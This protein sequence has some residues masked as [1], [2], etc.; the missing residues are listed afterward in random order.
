MRTKP[1]GHA[2]SAQLTLASKF[3]QSYAHL[4]RSYWPGLPSDRPYNI[5]LSHRHRF[6]WYRV[7]KVCTRSIFAAFDESEVTLDAD[8]PVKCYYA[9]RYFSEYFKFAFVRNPWDRL[10]SC[11]R[12]KVLER[13]Y[14]DLTP[15]ELH[16]LRD[17]GSFVDWVST[18]D[19]ETCDMHLRLQCRLI[20]L[21]HV[22][23]VGRFE[24]FE[25]DFRAVAD[26]IRLPLSEVPHENASAPSPS[27]VEVY[28]DQTKKR[29]AEIYKKD[30]AIFGFD[31]R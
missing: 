25:N 1:S 20:D 11:W 24:S 15:D 17:F 4:M 10:A 19:V 27:F 5:S 14:F 30:I 8:H 18:Q 21:D 3:Y 16:L 9:P 29:V 26:H 7:A 2:R 6:L 13:N 28:D 23:F 31:F 22:D 12:N